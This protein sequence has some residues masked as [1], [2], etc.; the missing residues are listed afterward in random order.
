MNAQKANYTKEKV[1][2][3]QRKLY[4]TA[5]KGKRRFHALYDKIYRKD[6][7]E[8]AWS[9][10]RTNRGVGGIDGIS[11]EKVEEYG[12]EK[13]LTEIEQ[14]LIAGNYRPKP[15]LRV[16]IP[17]SDGSKRQLGIPTIKDRIVQMATKIIIELLFES[18]FKDCSYGFRPKRNAHQ[19]LE[20]VRKACNNNGAY[21]ISK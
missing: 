5:N 12:A 15:V 9:R 6:V 8:E 7:L 16:E 20:V 2:K 19:A 11:I 17:K 10:V 4:L 18:D 13:L 14:D 3:L 1:R 21:V